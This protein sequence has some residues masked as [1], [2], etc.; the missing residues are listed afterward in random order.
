LVPD[1]LVVVEPIPGMRRAN[2]ET[3]V[4]TLPTAPDAPQ[5]FDISGPLAQRVSAGASRAG[6][7]R[8]RAFSPCR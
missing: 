7:S 4:I 1:V 5:H 6:G 8:R 3:A 2:H